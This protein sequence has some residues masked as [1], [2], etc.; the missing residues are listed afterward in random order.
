MASAP[1]ATT[2][3]A[4]PDPEPVEEGPLEGQRAVDMDKAEAEAQE[5]VDEGVRARG[6]QEGVKREVS[7]W[8]ETCVLL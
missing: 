8:R 7:A 1:E 3:A 2:P 5:R 4:W 6:G